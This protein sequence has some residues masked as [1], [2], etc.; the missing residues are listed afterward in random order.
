RRRPAKRRPSGKSRDARVTRRSR[1]AWMTQIIHFRVGEQ[2]SEAPGEREL[3]ACWRRRNKRDSLG[4][5]TVWRAGMRAF[6]RLWLG[7]GALALA[8]AAGAAPAE[9]QMVFPD[10]ASMCQWYSKRFELFFQ[11]R[12]A[13]YPREQFEEIIAQSATTSPLK[14]S[15]LNEVVA[16]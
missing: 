8:G 11:G 2:L 1:P 15:R 9:D 5:A 6:L 12:A 16:F 4:L 7:V 13:G 14:A 10:R 3:R